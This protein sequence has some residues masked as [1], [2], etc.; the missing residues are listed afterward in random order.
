MRDSLFSRYFFFQKHTKGYQR[1]NIEPLCCKWFLNSNSSY[2]S[3]SV[4]FTFKD[5]LGD[6]V[7]LFVGFLK[8]F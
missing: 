7:I 2:T 8:Q 3:K 1:G 6:R 4:V 5:L